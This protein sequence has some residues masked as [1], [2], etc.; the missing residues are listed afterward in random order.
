MPAAVPSVEI[1]DH[2][3]AL[4]VRRPD[5]EAHAVGVVDARGRGAEAV[6]HGGRVAGGE[7]GEHRVVEQRAERIRIVDHLPRVRPVDREQIV[8]RAA[9]ARDRSRE[10]AGTIDASERAEFGAFRRQ[11]VHAFR[12]GQQCAH[13]DLIGL[14][15]R[16]EARERIGMTAG[17][18]RID[19]G[20]FEQRPG[21]CLP[22]SSDAPPSSSNRSTSA[23][24]P[25]TGTLSQSGRF[26]AS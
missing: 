7:A 12:A 20:S 14:P 2:R 19:I 13:D 11:R 25:P 9:V 10:A 3:H 18:Q 21:H 17:E 24:R 26:A 15:V 8:G 6:E 16:A 22:P 5:R 1:A 4:R 23:A